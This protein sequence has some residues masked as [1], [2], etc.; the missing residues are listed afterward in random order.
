MTYTVMCQLA[1]RI[2]AAGPLISGMS[3]LQIAEC[4]PPRA[5][6]LFAL[7]G[8]NDNWQPYDGF[9]GKE[10]RLLSVPETVEFWRVRHRCT[11]Q[12]SKLLPH[13]LSEDTTRIVLS[14]WTGCATEG[15]VRLYRVNGGGHQ[16][17]TF[18]PGNPEWIKKAGRVNHDIETAEEFWSFAKKFR[19]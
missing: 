8:T 15:A 4:N 6:P 9:L 7:G 14:E 19:N 13:R 5:V 10:S 18:A 11:G 1:D 2:A 12:E 3:S 16:V 17:P